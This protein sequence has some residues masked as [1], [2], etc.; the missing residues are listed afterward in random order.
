MS[1][2]EKVSWNKI[3]VLRVEKNQHGK[4]LYK[5]SFFWTLV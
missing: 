3:K 2:S 1:N 4:I 5:K